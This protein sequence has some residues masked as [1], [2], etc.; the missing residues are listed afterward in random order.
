MDVQHFVEKSNSDWVEILTPGGRV[1]VHIVEGGFEVRDVS[2]NVI[3]RCTTT[4]SLY[5]SFPRGTKV[6]ARVSPGEWRSG[7]V[8]QGDDDTVVVSLV[9]SDSTEIYWS[10]GANVVVTKVEHIMRVSDKKDF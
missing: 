3:S 1:H 2:G 7:I 4:A 6:V 8:T 10:K 5:E 9:N